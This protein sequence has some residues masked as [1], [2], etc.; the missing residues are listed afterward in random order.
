VTRDCYPGVYGFL[1]SFAGAR[2]SPVQLPVPTYQPECDMRQLAD[3][4]DSLEKRIGPALDRR[5]TKEAVG[6]AQDFYETRIRGAFAY[7]FFESDY[8]RLKGLLSEVQTLTRESRPTDVDH[9]RRLMKRLANVQQELHKRMPS[10]DMFW[11]LV[12]D[13]GVMLGK[14]GNDAEPLVQCICEILEIVVR[15]QTR[16]EGLPLATE[17]PLLSGLA[18]TDAD[19]ENRS[20][21]AV[22]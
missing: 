6:R 7:E 10:L 11:G 21:R 2:G 13:A 17:N 22:S 20:L 16:A 5:R 4:I 8:K 15:T 3:L 18:Q 1:L 14:F 19:R 9:K 12:G